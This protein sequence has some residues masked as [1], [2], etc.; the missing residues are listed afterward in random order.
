MTN[1]TQNKA[2][3]KKKGLHKRSGEIMGNVWEFNSSIPIFV[4]EKP[5][6]MFY[7]EMFLQ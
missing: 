7:M 1:L 3:G 6:F 2:M 5:Y 4:L